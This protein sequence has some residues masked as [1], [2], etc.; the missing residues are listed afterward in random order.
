MIIAQLSDPHI[1]ARGMLFKCSIQG[2]ARDAERIRREFDTAQYLARAV[3]TINELV[4]RP[5]VTVVTGD[6]VDHGE[7]E[8]YEHLRALLAPLAMPVYVIPGNHDARAPLRDAFRTD[9]YLSDDGDLR[10]VIDGFP[11]RLVALDTLVTGKHYGSLAADQLDWLDAMLAAHRDRP[12]VVL[13][14][15]PPFAT[16]ITYMDNFRLDNAAALGTVIGRHPQVERI[17]CGHLHR[18]IDRRFAGTV[19]GT[20][21]G[22]A[23]QIRINLVPGAQIS[24]NFEPAGYQLHTWQ[25]GSLVTHTALLGEWIEPLLSTAR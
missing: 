2:V 8:E 14:H 3:A 25:D 21:P 9:G 20:A 1:V 13:M 10:Y 12:T 6:L 15:H 17:L 16:G 11:L 18:A 4:P 7:P 5:D 22:T 24:F 19:A 23:H